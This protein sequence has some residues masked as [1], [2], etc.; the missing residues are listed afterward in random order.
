MAGK[1]PKTP[2]TAADTDAGSVEPAS[3]ASTGFVVAW[4]CIQEAGK[5]YVQG[6]PYQPPTPELEEE[7]LGQGIIKRAG[8]VEE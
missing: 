6:E 5:T 1:A 2:Q 8:A 7:L 3:V 4:G